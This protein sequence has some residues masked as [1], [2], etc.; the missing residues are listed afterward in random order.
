MK[1]EMR[2]FITGNVA[3]DVTFKSTAKG[4]VASFRVAATPRKR[5]EQGVW[6]D[7]KTTYISVACWRQLA[8]NVGISLKIGQ[9]VIIEGR[10]E[11]KEWT[12]NDGINVTDYEVHAT[13]I[14]CDFNRGTGM[15]VRSQSARNREREGAEELARAA[16]TERDEEEG[17]KI[18][19]EGEPEW[20]ASASGEPD[21]EAASRA[22]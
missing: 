15:F 4:P 9:P 2:V 1:Q 5:D 6:Q 14:G 17:D 18:T 21:E 8:Q 16:Q 3:T 11:S 12:R 22:A 10:L 19:V 20:V 7:T 13:Y